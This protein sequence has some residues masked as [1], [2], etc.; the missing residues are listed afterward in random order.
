MFDGLL[1]VARATGFEV[2]YAERSTQE[3][4]DDFEES[5]RAGVEAAEDPVLRLA[6]VERERD[7]RDGYRGVLGFAWLVLAAARPRLLDALGRRVGRLQLVLAASAR[8]ASA[9]ADAHLA[10]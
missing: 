7:Y 5:W 3:E 8:C 4:W 9:G 2:V 6:A 10:G 1:Q